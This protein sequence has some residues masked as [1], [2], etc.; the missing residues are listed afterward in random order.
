MNDKSPTRTGPQKGKYLIERIESSEHSSRD[1][2]KPGKL[3]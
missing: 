1:A 3:R 2:S